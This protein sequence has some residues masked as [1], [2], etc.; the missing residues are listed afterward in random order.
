MDQH[1][2]PEPGPLPKQSGWWHQAG[3]HQT[4]EPVQD[5][6]RCPVCDRSV[7]GPRDCTVFHGPCWETL[8]QEL[9]PRLV[10]LLTEQLRRPGSAR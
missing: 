9:G 10:T 2:Q 4:S 5:P 6:G 7:D 8:R 3:Q 1:S